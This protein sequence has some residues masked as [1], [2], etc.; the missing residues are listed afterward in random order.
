MID[1]NEEILNIANNTD[2]DKNDHIDI[3]LEPKIQHNVSVIERVR[4]DL[5]LVSKV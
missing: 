5:Q 2:D 1:P 3:P 4:G